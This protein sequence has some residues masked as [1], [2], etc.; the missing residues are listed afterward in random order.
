MP[1]D[2]Y[3]TAT[4]Y[5]SSPYLLQNSAVLPLYS[6]RMLSIR[7]SRYELINYN[8]YK[9]MRDRIRIIGSQNTCR[10]AANMIC[11]I[12][13]LRH[14]AFSSGPQVRR[15]WSLHITKATSAMLCHVEQ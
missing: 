14:D 5:Y 11:S 7:V 10:V 3:I 9:V 12:S 13:H 15:V 1:L 8:T 2:E 6:V 4:S